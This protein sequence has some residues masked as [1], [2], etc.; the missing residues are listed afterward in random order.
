MKVKSASESMHATWNPWLLQDA[1]YKNLKLFRFFKNL[2]L[3][4]FFSDSAL[5]IGVSYAQNIVPTFDVSLLI[6]LCMLFLSQVIHFPRCK[7]KTRFGSAVASAV[8]MEVQHMFL[9]Q[10][11]NQH[12]RHQHLCQI[13]QRGCWLGH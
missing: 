12:R 2:K 7:T 5:S 8:R 13:G 11:S 9:L 3:F 1:V 10:L 6:R 4:R